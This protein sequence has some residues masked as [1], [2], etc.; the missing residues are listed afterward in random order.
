MRVKYDPKVPT[1]FI[2]FETNTIHLNLNPFPQFVAEHERLAKKVLSGAAAHESGH[3]IVSHPVW[4][5]YNNWVTKIKRNRGYFKLAHRLVNILEDRRI[6]HFIELRYRHDL[7]KRLKLCRLLVK[8][9]TETAIKTK[10]VDINTEHGEA[11]LI[12]GVLVNEG[13][14]EADC[15]ELYA[16]MSKKAKQATREAIS[17]LEEAKYKRFGMNLI[18]AVQ[19]IYDLIEPF[20]PKGQEFAC[21]NYI[22]ARVG[23]KIKGQ[24]SDKLKKALE[25]QI[26]KELEK[27]VEDKEKKLLEDLLKGSGAGEGTGEEIPTPEPNF[28]AYSALLDRNKEEITRL[29]DKLKQLLKPIIRRKRFEKRGKFMSQLLGKA[30]INSFRSVVKNVY[31]N[32][33]TQFEKEK[34]AI[35]FLFDF[36]GSVDRTEALDI[37]TVLT[38]VFGH[39]V[40]DYGFAVACFGA[41]SQKVKTFFEMFENTRARVGNISVNASGTEISVLLTSFLRMFNNITS[42]RRK[43]LVIASDFW[44]GDEDKALDLIK[45]YPKANV[46]LIFIGFC[47]CEKVDTWASDS[48]KAHR[49]AIKSV[50][51]LPEAFLDV[52]L[53]VQK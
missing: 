21:E 40:D 29:L 20:C 51:E 36:S 15:A 16:K 7:G 4:E 19:Q 2:D 13:L 14:Y 49:T 27:E 30:Y 53:N 45:L 26:K 42:D 8:D 44:F 38:E 39:Y 43:I 34:V 1:C 23:G 52:Y 33:K 6:N 10:Q 46:E 17:I 37:T 48:V 11:P 41:N 3:E 35:G 5:R 50:K 47:N 25:A 22:P 12:I 31:L 28:E 9:A 32:V 18:K 24:L